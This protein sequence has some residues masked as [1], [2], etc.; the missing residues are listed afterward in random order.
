M[1]P[2]DL[3][4]CTCANL[5]KAARVT[6][7]AFDAALQPTGLKSTQFTLLATLAGL[8]D[9]PLTRVADTLVMDRTTLTRN[10]KPLV[11]AGLVRI[12]SEA[13]QRV[14]RVALT[15]A[16]RQAFEAAQ[17]HWAKAQRRIL[18]SLGTARWSGF[19]QDLAATV[20]AARDR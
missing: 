1:N 11:R 5:R 12:E 2:M 3:Q 9:A 7:Q 17:P 10:L 14:R 19:L 16:G 8:G 13:D 6:T 18:E 4:A 20:Y 15:E